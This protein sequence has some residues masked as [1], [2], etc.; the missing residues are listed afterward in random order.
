MVF[1]IDSATHLSVGSAMAKQSYVVGEP[2]LIYLHLRNATDQT[3]SAFHLP[4][5][6]SIS[7]LDNSVSGRDWGFASD[8]ETRPSSI[9]RAFGSL[10]PGATYRSAFILADVGDSP[11]PGKYRAQIHVTILRSLNNHTPI[12][13]ISPPAID[14][15]VV[16]R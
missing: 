1:R 11:Q 13:E 8:R 7:K 5:T 10:T 6:V 15:T 2:I 14:F 12:G 4:G 9:S 3:I 16:S